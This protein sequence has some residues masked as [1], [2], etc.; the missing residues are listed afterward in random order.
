MQTW[1]T[2]L[3]SI[4]TRYTHLLSHANTIYSFI[5][6]WKNDILIYSPMQIRHAHLF[7][8][9]NMTYMYSFTL[10]CKHNILILS[11]HS[12]WAEHQHP[13][14]S[15]YS[16][17]AGP[18]RTLPL[19]PTPTT[20]QLFMLSRTTKHPLLSSYSCWAGPPSTHFY[21][22][23][24]VE[25]DHQAP[26]TIQLFMLSWH[27]FTIFLIRSSYVLYV[28]NRLTQLRALLTVVILMC[29]HTFTHCRQRA[30]VENVSSTSGMLQSGLLKEDRDYY[31]KF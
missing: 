26:T 6:P 9:T 22:A 27:T 10:P 21:P 2:H 3:L 19:P 15:S 16:C 13:P 17:W 18:P 25:P 1:H 12:C 7:S 24:H 14:L 4:Q 5:F 23:I 30:P 20:I 31:P 11:S 29:W 8:H 28:S